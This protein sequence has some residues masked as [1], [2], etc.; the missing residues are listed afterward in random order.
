M[1][2]H[3]FDGLTRKLAQGT[4][5]RQALKFLAG[6]VAGGVAGV[7]G[8]RVAV[9]AQADGSCLDDAEC[10]AAAADTI[11]PCATGTCEGAI[12]FLGVRGTCQFAPGNPGAICRPANGPCD[13]PEFCS[14]TSTACPVDTFAPSGT[15]C[16]PSTGPCDIADFCTGTSPFCTA[17]RIVHFAFAPRCCHYGSALAWPTRR[18]SR[19]RGRLA[20]SPP[21]HVRQG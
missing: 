12:P 3:R 20:I 13:R 4:T 8:R 10:R 7:F 9:Q 14:G 5:R 17:D 18:S 2:D 21:F 16:R 19:Y 15:M 6:G 1:D 11:G